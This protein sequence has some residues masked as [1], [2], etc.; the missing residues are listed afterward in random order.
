MLPRRRPEKVKAINDEEAL[1]FE[2]KPVAMFV[3]RGTVVSREFMS[4]DG[5]VIAGYRARPGVVGFPAWTRLGDLVTGHR[6]TG[7]QWFSTGVAAYLWV[8]SR[9][10][11]WHELSPVPTAI[12]G[13]TQSTWQK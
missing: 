2:I 8:L 13:G 5:R 1:L 6:E 10:N 12:S 9:V 7:R 4:H 11:G 3:D